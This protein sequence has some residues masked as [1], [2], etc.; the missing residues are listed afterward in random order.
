MDEFLPHF[1]AAATQVRV[2]P[3]P[4]WERLQNARGLIWGGSAVATAA[5]MLLVT[6]EP[7]YIRPQPAIVQMQSLR[8][9]EAKAQIAW[10]SPGLLIF[11]VPIVPGHADYEIEI[12]GSTGNGILKGDGVVKDDQLTF[13]V[14]KLAPAAY[15]VRVYRRQPAR[16]LVAEYGLQAK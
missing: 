9:P 7:Q 15:W 3:A 5:I 8:G 14:Q 10:G 1:R 16:V 4:F 13:R 6:G 11:D 2:R 12:V